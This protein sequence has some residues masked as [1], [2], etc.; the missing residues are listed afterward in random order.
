M[1]YIIIDDEPIARD[2]I[3]LMAQA[4][5]Q[6]TF[7]GSFG[8][9]VVATDF[10]KQNKVDLIFLDI[11]M[12]EQNGLEFAETLENNT[13]IILRLL[14]RSMQQTVMHWMLLIT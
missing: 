1:N 5:D 6:F 2:G 3:Q 10:M 14:M 9:P 4:F 12:P 8:S 13:L 7:C 11:N